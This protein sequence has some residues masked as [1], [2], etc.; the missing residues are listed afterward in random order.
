VVTYTAVLTV[1]NCNLLLRPGMTAT[2]QIVTQEVPDARAV[3]NAA[4]RYQPPK[5]EQSQGFSI[6]SIFMPRM[7]RFEKSTAQ[8]TNGERIIWVLENGVPRS[9][10]IRTG[11]SDGKVTEVVS[12]DLA[13][14]ADVILSERQVKK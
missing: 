14:G 5:V 7:P 1:D 13:P 6:T 12:G 8:V 4:L 2:A 3:P 11:V 10:A 9:V